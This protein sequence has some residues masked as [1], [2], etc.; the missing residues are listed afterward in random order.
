M[1]RADI[2]PKNDLSVKRGYLPVERWFLRQICK[3][4]GPGPVRLLF[5]DS[6]E[7]SAPNVSPVATVRIHDYRTLA[8]MMVDPEVAFGEAHAAGRVQVEGDLVRLLEA[9]YQSMASVSAGANWYQLLTSYCMD[10]AQA[11]TLHGSRNNIHT[12]YDLGND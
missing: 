1:S 11:N 7:I 6:E 4:I 9:V 2:A 5:M 12:H 3:A 10:C 8:Q